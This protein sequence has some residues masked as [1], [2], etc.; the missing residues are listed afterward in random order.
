MSFPQKR[1]FVT[2][3]LTILFSDAPFCLAQ[4]APDNGDVQSTNSNAAAMVGTYVGFFG[5][6]KITVS[7]EKVVGRTIL[8]YSIV[9]ANERAFSG[10]WQEVPEGIAF[11][12][13]EPGDHPEDGIFSM[14]FNVQTK[15]LVGRYMPVALDVTTKL[16]DIETKNAALIKRYE[17]Y[18][19]AYYDRFG[20]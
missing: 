20:R 9:T 14:T 6:H 10:S 2:T 4:K 19:A 18:G 12:A 13:N 7:I 1:F 5:P 3:L 8:G 17:N 11:R 15:T 16:T